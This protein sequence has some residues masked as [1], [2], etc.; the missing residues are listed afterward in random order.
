MIAHE[1][2]WQLLEEWRSEIERSYELLRQS[3]ALLYR[4][5]LF[6]KNSQIQAA[7]SFFASRHAEAAAVAAAVQDA[8]SD[9]SSDYELWCDGE[10]LLL[11]GDDSQ[12]ARE[13]EA[14]IEAHQDMVL[15]LEDKLH[16]SFACVR[17]SRK[18]QAALVQLRAQRCR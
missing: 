11:H 5:Y 1:R 8:C 12:T 3:S 15:D 2:R 10:H 17:R 9:V 14:T 16:T 13:H 7:E 4:I 6:D 18:L